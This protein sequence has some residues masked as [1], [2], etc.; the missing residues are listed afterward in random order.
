[1]ECV[2]FVIRKKKRD[3]SGEC[4]QLPHNGKSSW[5]TERVK[6]R[7]SFV[8]V[9]LRYTPSLNLVSTFL[10]LDTVV[11]LCNEWT[12]QELIYGFQ[13]LVGIFKDSFYLIILPQGGLLHVS[14]FVCG[15]FRQGV[16]LQTQQELHIVTKTNQERT[17]KTTP[18][19]VKVRRVEEAWTH[20]KKLN[21]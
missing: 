11:T 8:L 5:T 4:V 17:I 7:V 6:E 14:V 2:R 9:L 18:S 12:W 21:R 20:N 16:D 15:W 19:V 3:W 13:S 10:L 1:M